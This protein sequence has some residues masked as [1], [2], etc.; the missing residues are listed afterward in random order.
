MVKKRNCN[1][2]VWRNPESNVFGRNKRLPNVFAVKQ[3]VKILYTR[4]GCYR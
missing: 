4:N 2:F 3:S 1:E